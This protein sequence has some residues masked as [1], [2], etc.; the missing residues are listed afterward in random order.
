MRGDEEKGGRGEC[1][2][3]FYF[4]VVLCFFFFFFNLR[5]ILLFQAKK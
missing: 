1:S 5:R 2:I 4:G 3:P